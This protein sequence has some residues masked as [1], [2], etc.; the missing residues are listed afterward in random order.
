MAQLPT[1]RTPAFVGA[2]QAHANDH[3]ELHR[4]HNVVDGLPYV[5]LQL[6]PSTEWEIDHNLGLHPNV[7]VEDSSGRLVFGAV[8]YES[9]ARLVITFSAAFGGTAYLTL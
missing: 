6:V 1:N 8:D 7:H 5:H 2:R 4:L 3:N 9:N